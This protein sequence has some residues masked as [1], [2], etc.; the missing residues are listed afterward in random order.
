LAFELATIIAVIVNH[1]MWTI[2][3]QTERK[4]Q[5]YAD[6]AFR[7]ATLR[8]YST[9]SFKAFPVTNLAG[10]VQAAIANGMSGGKE[11]FSQYNYY[12]SYN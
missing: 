10:F 11:I 4:R 9:A 3:D 8:L 12:K 1:R 2:H 6:P 7:L 5:S